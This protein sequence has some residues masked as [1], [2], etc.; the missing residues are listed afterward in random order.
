M[1]LAEKLAREIGRVT[2]L[3]CLYEILRGR[4]QVVVEPAIAMM[5]SS[6]EAAKIAAAGDVAAMVNALEDLGEYEK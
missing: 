1:N 6:L 5:N 2:E 3:R 4:P